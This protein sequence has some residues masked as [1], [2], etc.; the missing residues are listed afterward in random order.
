M[1]LC[2]HLLAVPSGCGK[3]SKRRLTL[4]GIHAITR[5]LSDAAHSAAPPGT[6]IHTTLGA[7][8]KNRQAP[9]Q[10]DITL[11]SDKPSSA[12]YE[13]SKMERSLDAVATRDR[14]VKDPLPCQEGICFAYAN[15]GEETH[16][17]H[18][19]VRPES[20]QKIVESKNDSSGPKL[21]IILDDLGGD[22]RVAEEIFDLPYPLTL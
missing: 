4:V 9:D 22:R 17:V 1:V 11:F 6:Q 20:E 8:D 16:V 13:A 14:L 5:E 21:A 2:A 12:R 7:P 18:I 3:P 10:L 15:L 19:H